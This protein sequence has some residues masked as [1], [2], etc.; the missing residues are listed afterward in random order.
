MSNLH[1]EQEVRIDAD[2]NRIFN[3]LTENVGSWWSKHFSEIPLS[4]CLEPVIGGRFYEEF[5]E[6]GSGALFATVSYIDRDKVLAMHGPMGMPN[7]VV[8]FIRFDLETLDD[9][10]LLKLSHQVLGQV[11][12]ERWGSYREGWKLLLEEGLK[13]FVESGKELQ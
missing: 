9:S 12:E 7:P 4:I 2:P 10:T 13:K 1:I 5:D 11:E 8:N 6:G 3:A